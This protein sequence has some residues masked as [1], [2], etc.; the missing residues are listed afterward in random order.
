MVGQ[1]GTKSGLIEDSETV[2][3]EL[4]DSCTEL[5]PCQVSLR[6]MTSSLWSF[7]E[8]AENVIH[9]AINRS[10]LYNVHNMQLYIEEIG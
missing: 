10:F 9:F 5:L 8:E 2:Q 1:K 7:F 4:A 6:S 3:T